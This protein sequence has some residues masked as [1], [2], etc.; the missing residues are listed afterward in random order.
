MSINWRNFESFSLVVLE[1]LKRYHDSYTLPKEHIPVISVLIKLAWH[2]EHCGR[3]PSVFKDN[4]FNH[5]LGWAGFEIIVHVLLK[6]HFCLHFDIE[7]PENVSKCHI[8][9]NDLFKSLTW[10]FAAFAFSFPI[11]KCGKELKHYCI[12]SLIILH[13][14]IFLLLLLLL[15]PLLL[16][17][18]LHL[19]VMMMMMMMITV[20]ITIINIMIVFIALQVND[21]PDTLYARTICAD[22]PPAEH[23]LSAQVSYLHHTYMV[24]L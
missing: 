9:W 24:V 23:R 8:S 14:C 12:K 3:L 1:F 15:F 4:K 18:P 6:G 21:H 13:F 16:V 2:V 10:L 5:K 7:I 22:T 17:L 19:L 20:I 11:S